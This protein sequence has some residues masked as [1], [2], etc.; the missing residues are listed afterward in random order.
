MAAVLACGDGALLAHR[1]A[2]SL[3]DLMPG[4]GTAVID[5]VA[6]RRRSHRGIRS[7]LGGDTTLCGTV[8]DGIPV[9]SLPVTLLHV[10]A[11]MPRRRAVAALEQ[12]QRIGTL[13]ATPIHALLEACEGHRGAAILAAALDAL[14]DDPPWLQSDTEE[15]F[16]ALL[17]DHHLPLPICNQLV[18]GELVD[19][20]WPDRKLVVELDGYG[21]HSSRR[22]F[23]SDRRRDVVLTLAGFTVVRF[24]RSQVLQ[25]PDAVM[26]AMRRLLE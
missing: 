21:Y 5:V 1:A 9:T 6:P 3:H 11:T 2:A 14:A 22:A 26:T 19:C 25:S 15:R 7:H 17:S 20:L 12:A 8:I 16:R 10:A 18:E 23:D 4:P 13:D 24:T